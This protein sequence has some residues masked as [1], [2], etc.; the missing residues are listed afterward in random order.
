MKAQIFD[1]L[2]SMSIIG[3]LHSFKMGCGSNGIFEGAA[4]RLFSYFFKKSAAAAFVK[5]LSLE[6]K[7]L[8]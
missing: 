4:M 6:S 5:R 2:D 8:H 3:F 1:P 7:S